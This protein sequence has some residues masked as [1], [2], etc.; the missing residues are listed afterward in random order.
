MSEVFE[1]TPAG[2]R[3][4]SADKRAVERGG[5]KESASWKNVENY[6]ERTICAW[7]VRALSPR[8]KQ[9]KEVSRAG[10]RRK[11][12]RNTRSMAAGI[13]SQR[14][15]VQAKCCHDTDCNEPMLKKG[16]TTGRMRHRNGTRKPSGKCESLR[17]GLRQ[18]QRGVRFGST[19]RGRKD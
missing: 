6:E 12:G 10:R 18:D 5:G 3:R 1:Q 2:K 7:D 4:K 14:V 11:A 17:M 15:P 16:F 19:G 9:S 8:K 13:A